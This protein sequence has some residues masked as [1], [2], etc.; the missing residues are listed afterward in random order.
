MCERAGLILRER[1]GRGGGPVVRGSLSDCQLVF[2]RDVSDDKDRLDRQAEW[3]SLDRAAPLRI[4][5]INPTAIVI[6]NA[7]S[8]LV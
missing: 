6:P 3:S 4:L 8:L 7:L 2:N 1:R 5:Y